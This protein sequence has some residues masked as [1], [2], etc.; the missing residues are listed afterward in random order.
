MN[1][2]KKSLGVLLTCILLISFIKLDAQTPCAFPLKSKAIFNFSTGTIPD[3]TLIVRPTANVSTCDLQVTTQKA[4]LNAVLSWNGDY[5]LDPT[6]TYSVLI[7][8]KAYRSCNF[9]DELL[10][11]LTF[12]PWK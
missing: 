12:P 10:E 3:E 2:F 5:S 4:N 11:Q 6:T 1:I 8:V 7:T 9:P